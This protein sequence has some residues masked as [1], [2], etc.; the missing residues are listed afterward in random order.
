MLL[1]CRKYAEPPDESFEF[2]GSDSEDSSSSSGSDL[3]SDDLADCKP[4]S[5]GDDKLFQVRKKRPN[6]DGA[7]PDL[8]RKVIAATPQ[9]NR[10][11]APC[12]EIVLLRQPPWSVG[13]KLM[14]FLVHSFISTVC[15][16]YLAA[17]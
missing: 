17:K 9:S 5:K 15:T 4:P 3:A 10:G 12:L 2:T 6:G 11:S 16:F 14:Q 1:L 13:C 7:T 8:P